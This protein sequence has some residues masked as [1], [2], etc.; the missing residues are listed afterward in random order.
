MR[1]RLFLTALLG[2]A[3]LLGACIKN[4]TETAVENMISA[5]APQADYDIAIESD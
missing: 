3:L 4:E 5:T 1:I 2:A